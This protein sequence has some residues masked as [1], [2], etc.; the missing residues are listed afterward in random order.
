[1]VTLQV[2]TTLYKH[3]RQVMSALSQ[4]CIHCSAMLATNL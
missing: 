1:M 3:I 4:L 2:L